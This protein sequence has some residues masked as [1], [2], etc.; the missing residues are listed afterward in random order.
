MRFRPRTTTG[1]RRGRHTVGAVAATAAMIVAAVAPFSLSA[2]PARGAGPSGSDPFTVTGAQL[3][4]GVNNESNNRAFAP[5]THNFFSAGIVP[6]PGRGGTT[7]PQSSWRASEGDVRIEK[8]QADGAYALATWDGLTTTPQGAT[9]TS[10][11]SGQFSNHQ[12]VLGAG[13]GTVDPATGFATIAWKGS[14][15]VLFYSGMSFFTVTDPTLTVTPERAQLTATA[16]GFA[17][18][19]EDQAQWSALPPTPVVLADLPRAE[20]DL[21]AADGFAS[22][23]AYLGVDWQVP[24]DESAQVG[25]QW[26][27]AFPSSF[28]D[29]LATAGT[30]GYWYSTGGSTDAYKPA[31]P[32]TVSW[33]GAPVVAPSPSPTATP[34]KPTRTP[35][36]N[37]TPKPTEAPTAAPSRPP[38]PTAAPTASTTRPLAPAPPGTPSSVDAATAP[39]TGV[40]A[41]GSATS[42][43]AVQP[44]LVQA[45]T[46]P[47]TSAA[48]AADDTESHVLWLLGCV[49]LLGALATTLISTSLVSK[50][51]EGTK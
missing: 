28:L 16:G 31:L 39:D 3:R 42:P 7:L 21:T 40:L 50:P 37:A 17:S 13:S 26:K 1:S 51:V 49:L 32:L 5:G 30:A 9:I 12:V 29:F 46:S 23:P 34:T 24:A 2:G 41:G 47:P 20:V 11:A 33:A 43:L 25:G 36:K 44:V 45:A 15:T 19:M 10:P 27:G 35:T 48:P 18:D 14:F 38:S 4:W 8:Q 6:D 22:T